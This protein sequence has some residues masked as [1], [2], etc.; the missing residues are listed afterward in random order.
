MINLYNVLS[1]QLYLDPYGKC[2]VGKDVR[3]FQLDKDLDK[4]DLVEDQKV[5]FFLVKFKDV[6]L[7]PLMLPNKKIFGFIFK[8]VKTKNFL[9]YVFKEE[10]PS[11]F[12]LEDFDDFEFNKPIFLL[13]GIKECMLFKIFYKYTLAYL[14]GQ[15]SK[16]LF[17]YLKQISNRLIFIPDNDEVGKRL[18]YFKKFDNYN[19]YFS[20]K[21]KDFGVY[22]ENDDR[23]IVEEVK[24]ILKNEGI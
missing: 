20:Y 11:V 21:I 19:K 7:I 6:Y 22:W 4:L 3:T 5:K 10:T 18:K 9:K 2:L 12:G 8:S 23:S 1:K 14:T 13:E 15:P 17:E 24:F 16:L